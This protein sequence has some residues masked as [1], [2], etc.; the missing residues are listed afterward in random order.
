MHNIQ[1]FDYKENVDQ[2]KVAAE[3]QEYIEENGEYG[4]DGIRWCRETICANR[5]DAEK[6]IKEHDNNWYDNIAVRYYDPI[7]ERSQKLD[8]LSQKIREAYALYSERNNANYIKTR[9]SEFI[10][11]GNCK[12]R[13]A[14]KYLRGNFCPICGLDLRPDTMIKSIAAAKNKWEN[15]QKTKQEYIN[16]HS[17]KEVRWLVKFEYHT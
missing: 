8:E 10:G 4:G 17:K 9:T 13:M 11:C 12:S 14:A 15:A 3:I 7:I 1:Y 5:Q 6:W 2:K 16:K